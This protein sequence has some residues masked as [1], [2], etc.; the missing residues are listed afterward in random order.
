MDYYQNSW[1][2]HCVFICLWGKAEPN[3]ADTTSIDLQVK[4]LHDLRGE[5]VTTLKN[6]TW[7]TRIL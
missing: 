6:L 3:H 5:S 1:K 4:T 7:T 2:I